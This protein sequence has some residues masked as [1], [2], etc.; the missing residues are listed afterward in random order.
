[1]PLTE[2]FPYD[3]SL[4]QLPAYVVEY[5]G[6]KE[7]AQFQKTAKRQWIMRGK[8]CRPFVLT[9]DN[10][11]DAI[12]KLRKEVQRRCR[13]QNRDLFVTPAYYRNPLNRR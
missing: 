9:A 13:H 6:G 3:L 10:K 4:R 5:F 1:M 7:V 11:I 12:A 2:T 8:N